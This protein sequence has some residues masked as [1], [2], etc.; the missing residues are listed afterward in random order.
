MV[1]S[2]EAG[3]ET[4]SLEAVDHAEFA[5]VKGGLVVTRLLRVFDFLVDHVPQS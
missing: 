2:L 5:S 3:Y 4:Y 1:I